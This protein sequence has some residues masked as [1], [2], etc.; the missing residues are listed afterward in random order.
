MAD[1]DIDIIP[2]C[3]E[4][5]SHLLYSGR[6][7]K[8]GDYAVSVDPCETCIEKAVKKERDQQEA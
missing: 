3:R 2:T 8:Q 6:L 4:C 7:N 5:G 1:I